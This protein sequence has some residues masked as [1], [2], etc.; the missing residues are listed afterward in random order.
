ML[1]LLLARTGLSL[2]PPF[3]R[4]EGSQAGSSL[5]LIL[6]LPHWIG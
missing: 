3:P 5:S 6:L 2:L 4:K 1:F